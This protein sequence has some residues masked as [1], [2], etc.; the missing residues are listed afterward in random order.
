[1]E[2]VGGEGNSSIGRLLGKPCRIFDYSRRILEG[3]RYQLFRV[4]ACW[5]IK[6]RIRCRQ[7]CKPIVSVCAPYI[8]TLASKTF[9]EFDNTGGIAPITSFVIDIKTFSDCSEAWIYLSY[10]LGLLIFKNPHPCPKMLHN[11][12]FRQLASTSGLSLSTR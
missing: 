11:H 10:L 6:T 5:G 1:M 12:K 3:L 9:L 4:V 2:S 7:V 8:L